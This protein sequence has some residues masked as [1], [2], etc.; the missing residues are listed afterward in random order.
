MLDRGD[1]IRT[2][3]DAEPRRPPTG[4]SP[5]PME[6]DPTV[7]DALIGRTQASLAALKHDIQS[8]AGPAL[9]DFIVADLQE[10]KR[11]LFDPQSHQVN[12]TEGYVEILP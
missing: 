9:L 4:G 7:I 11:L 8:K 1:V 3:P 12:G 10:L 5:P 2:V 6:T